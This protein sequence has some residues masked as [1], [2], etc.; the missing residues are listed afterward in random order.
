M[1]MTFSSY[2]QLTYSRR[3]RMSHGSWKTESEQHSNYRPL[4][5]SSVFYNTTSHGVML[6]HVLC[7]IKCVDKD[8][9]SETS[10]F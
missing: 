3:Q 9:E 6:D 5:P 4:V 1:M 7:F 8:W 10:G 2:R